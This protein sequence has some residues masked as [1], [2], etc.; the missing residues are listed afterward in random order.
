MVPLSLDGGSQVLWEDGERVFRRGWQLDNQ[1]KRR[2]V[3]IV[4]PA[5]DHP[6]R[7]SF[8]RLTH[9]YSLKDELDATWAARPLG[10]VHDAGRTMLVLEDGSFVQSLRATTQERLSPGTEPTQT[11]RIARKRWHGCSRCNRTLRI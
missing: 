3:M 9:E 1:G 11:S 7:S 10:L 8:D 6:S 4:L 5:A 2:S